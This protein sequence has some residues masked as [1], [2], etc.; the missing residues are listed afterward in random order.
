MTHQHRVHHGAFVVFE[1]V[2]FQHTQALAWL[3]LHRSFIGFQLTADGTEQGR[4]AR[5]VGT[6]DT[7]DV[8]T[9]EFQVDVL[10]EDFLSKLYLQICYC[11]HCFLSIPYL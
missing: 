11:N 9:R 5:T 3:H 10:I 7:V 2:L 6:D 4:L 1:V 8:A